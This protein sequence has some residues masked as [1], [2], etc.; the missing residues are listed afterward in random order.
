[1]PNKTTV[2]RFIKESGIKKSW[3]AARLR[4]SVE[5]LW[6]HTSE[7]RKDLSPELRLKALK[8]LKRL[9]DKIL[10]FVHG[11]GII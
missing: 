3:L 6:Y 9:A 4:M 1:M 11:E 10:E 2:L 8:Q 5:S 7:G